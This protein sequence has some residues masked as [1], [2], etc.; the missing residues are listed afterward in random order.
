[1]FKKPLAHQSNATPIR[2]SARR[3]LINAIFAQY[4]LLL[5]SG[6]GEAKEQQDEDAIAVDKEIGRLIV[7][8]GVRLGT[9]ETSAEIQGTL[10]Y[11]PSGDPLW[12]TIGR[13]SSTYIPTLCLLSL[14]LPRPPLPTIQIYHPLP[15]PLFTGAPL[16]L[17][18]VRNLNNLHLIPDVPEGGVVAFVASDNN[19]SEVRY[20][21]AGIVVAQGGI[22]G[23]VERRKRNRSEGREVEEGKFCDV[24][25]MI[26][27]HLWQ[28]GS[29]PTLLTFTL[30]VPSP[31]LAPPPASED[32]GLSENPIPVSE[33][34]VEMKDLRIDDSA[35]PVTP[36]DLS[37]SDIST[38][39]NQALY[40][41]LSTSES[42][43][44]PMPASTLY[45]AHIFPNRPAYI[46]KAQRDEVVIGKSEWKK[47]TKWMKEISKDGVIKMKES[48]GE[49]VVQG[50]DAKHMALQTHKPFLTVS[51]EEA[52]ATKKATREAAEAT[53]A[54]ASGSKGKSRHIEELWRPSGSGIAFWEAAGV[55]TTT[56]QPS[57]QLKASFEDYVNRNSLSDPSDRRMIV[58][59]DS[60]AKAI[61][62]KMG[63]SESRL[64]REEV[65]RR[66]RSG[67]SWSVSIDGVVKKGAMQ[68][69]LISVKT[70]QGRKTVTLI[71]G[72]E[73]FGID[74][75][76]F[77]EELKKLCAGS[78]AIQPLQGA[79][80]KLNLREIMVQGTQTK[81]VTDALVD[82]GV[83]KRY[84]KEGDGDKK[85]K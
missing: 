13:S 46:P 24:L 19:G 45:S 55:E 57:S 72:L 41:T 40:Q 54:E 83:P 3:Q 33:S 31:G 52:R 85:K 69:V 78:T 61:G 79:S 28:M 30:P 23:A 66:L 42:L 32:S 75:E 68:P 17:P 51:E 25:Y 11:S 15:P 39:L 65:I 9:F 27:D 82:K 56:L 6:R 43:S 34:I 38:L 76:D 50:Y 2:S 20:V 47:L 21:G 5:S 84:I 80:P 64:V 10:Y 4:P 12:M 77:A 67:V 22:R 36:A 48:K 37:P 7:P 26:N 58:L 71:S 59:D 62:V 49:I 1:M 81:I 16:F 29:K 44:F 73:T 35:A 63:S 53:G 60:L 18:A 8:E 74:L 14:S 70:R